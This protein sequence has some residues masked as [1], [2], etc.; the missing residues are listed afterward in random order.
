M[1]FSPTGKTK[2]IAETIGDSLKESLSVS[3]TQKINI[4]DVLSPSSREKIYHFDSDDI[5]IVACPTY[6]GRVPNKIMPFFQ[7]NIKGDGCKCLCIVTFGGRSYDESLKELYQLMKANGF[8]VIAGGAFV[9]QH[10]MSEKLSFGR[11]NSNDLN[12]AKQF[13]TYATKMILSNNNEPFSVLEGEVG[14][15]YIPLKVD[16]TKAVFLKAK[17]N[18]DTKKCISCKKCASLCPMGSIVFSDIENDFANCNSSQKHN[19]GFPSFDGICIKCH[20]CIRM[21]PSK[22]LYFDDADLL[23][24]VQMLEENYLDK[25]PEN[26]LFV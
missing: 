14:P 8:R 19:I 23:S 20:A 25:H 3:G 21:C 1:Y 15:Y 12:E 26:E 16:K 4:I 24:H 17:P 6:A 22:A 5:L 10:S 18:V 9:C 11:P 13:G 7:N 2:L